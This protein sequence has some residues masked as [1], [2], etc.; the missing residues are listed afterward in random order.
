MRL[1][2][3]CRFLWPL[4]PL[5][6]MPTNRDLCHLNW[7]QTQRVSSLLP[8]VPFS[9]VLWSYGLGWSILFMGPLISPGRSLPRLG[10]S[11]TWTSSSLFRH[12][13]HSSLITCS[14][15]GLFCPLQS[16]GENWSTRGRSEESICSMSFSAHHSSFQTA[17][18]NN[19]AI[20]FPDTHFLQE[21]QNYVRL[22]ESLWG[23]WRLS[24]ASLHLLY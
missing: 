7:H 13:I 10:G 18:R 11:G 14:D 15:P 2:F 19:F 3:P 5:R 8:L 16:D 17:Y 22:S 9:K 21:I 20:S 12:A 4:R 6:S 23:W 24:L 1:E